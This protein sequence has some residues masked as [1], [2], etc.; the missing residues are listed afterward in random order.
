MTDVTDSTSQP[1]PGAADSDDLHRA[2]SGRRR[3]LRRG[4]VVVGSAAS[5]AVGAVLGG[6]FEGIPVLFPPAAPASH[7][8]RLA[9]SG[10]GW[11]ELPVALSDA[12]L[13]AAPPPRPTP[14]VATGT[15][16]PGD[17]GTVQS[18]PPPAAGPT[19][20]LPP[21][22]TGTLPSPSVPVPLP[23]TGAPASGSSTGS[24][25]SACSTLQQTTAPLQSG[26]GAIPAVG[27]TLSGAV[28]T[29]TSTAGGLVQTATQVLGG[30]TGTSST[31]TSSTGTQSTGTG[32]TGTGSSGTSSST[33]S[34]GT[35]GSGTTVAVPGTGASVTVGGSG[36]SGG[37]QLGPISIQP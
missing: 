19:S 1:E 21:A 15:A 34:S 17:V 6:V 24:S 22:P 33:T 14:V 9:A 5:L 23:S 18:P 12:E 13:P 32:S 28:G 3:W 29:V 11:R 7:G 4:G 36:S 20:S 10:G 25:C 31:G 27:G 2:V 37:V 26:L 8:P 16:V 35:G 30:S